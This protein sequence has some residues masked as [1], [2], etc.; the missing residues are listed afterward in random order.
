[1]DLAGINF[2][3]IYDEIFA[4][5]ETILEDEK[6]LEENRNPSNAKKVLESLFKG[7]VNGPKLESTIKDKTHKVDIFSLYSQ[8]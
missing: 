4:E 7:P 5:K 2:Q 6:N 8:Y 3:D 1:M